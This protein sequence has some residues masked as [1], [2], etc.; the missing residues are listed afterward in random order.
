MFFHPVCIVVFYAHWQ[1]ATR[2][3]MGIRSVQT[4]LV[5]KLQ[6]PATC[7]GEEVSRSL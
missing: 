7:F 3:L 1:W 5:N 6:Q 4:N 2:K